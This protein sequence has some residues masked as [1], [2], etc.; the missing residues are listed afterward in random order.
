MAI[1][2]GKRKYGRKKNKKAIHSSDTNNTTTP[3]LAG[4]NH[5]NPEENLARLDKIEDISEFLNYASKFPEF[6]PEMFEEMTVEE[7]GMV[8]RPKTESNYEGFSRSL[9]EKPEQVLL[10][11][12]E[13]FTKIIPRLPEKDIAYSILHKSKHKVPLDFYSAPVVELIGIL[14]LFGNDVLNTPAASGIVSYIYQTIEAS[15]ISGKTANLVICLNFVIFI[16]LQDFE[17]V[18]LIQL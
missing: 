7:I 13:K 18:F 11:E 14:E 15:N 1:G 6:S 3:Y 10:S 5:E 2:A 4:M 16:F 8:A 12:K 17:N 9:T